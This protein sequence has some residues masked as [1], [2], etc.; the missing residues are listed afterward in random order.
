MVVLE[1]RKRSPERPQDGRRGAPSRSAR[2]RRGGLSRLIVALVSG[3]LGAAV[4]MAAIEI[5]DPIL[6]PVGQSAVMPLPGIG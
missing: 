2:P 3:L 4:A 5:A 6:F 1:M